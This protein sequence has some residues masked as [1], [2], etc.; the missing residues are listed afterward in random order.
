MS[1]FLFPYCLLGEASRLSQWC[2]AVVCYAV[3]CYAVVQQCSVERESKPNHYILYI[4]LLSLFLFI[5]NK[6]ISK[7]WGLGLFYADPV[8]FRVRVWFEWL[9]SA[10]SKRYSQPVRVER[11]CS[12]LFG[13]A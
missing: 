9:D 7:T 4:S 10:R 11:C 5:Y 3:V 2:Y 13:F 8:G 6:T 12:L 1:C